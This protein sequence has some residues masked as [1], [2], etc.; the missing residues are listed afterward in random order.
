MNWA[1]DIAAQRSRRQKK[2]QRDFIIQPGVD[3]QRLRWV[4]K[5]KMT[6]NS[7]GV[8][9]LRAKRRCNRVAVGK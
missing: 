7:E 1:S 2:S 6:T 9:S 5:H 8:E 4:V 3:A